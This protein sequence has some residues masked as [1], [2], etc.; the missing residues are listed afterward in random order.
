MSSTV[1]LLASWI[2]RHGKAPMSWQCENCKNPLILQKLLKNLSA[3]VNWPP[4][5]TA[6]IAGT[7]LEPSL[8][9]RLFTFSASTM[10]QAKFCVVFNQNCASHNVCGCHSLCLR[11]I[12]LPG[13][14]P[15]SGVLHPT[16]LSSYISLTVKSCELQGGLMEYMKGRQATLAH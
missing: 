4:L 15:A 3:I 5:N 6:A 16:P 11:Y 9:V 1:P 13:D 2:A 14:P 7:R 8:L 10:V 12:I